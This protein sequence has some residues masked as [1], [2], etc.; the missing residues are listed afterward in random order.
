M[1]KKDPKLTVLQFNECINNQDA[2]GLANLMTEGIL[3][4]MGGQTTQVGKD[5]NTNA[6]AAFFNMCPD[7]KNHFTRI[8]SKDDRVVII[9]FSTCSN[10][11]V[12]G[13]ALWTAKVQND[14]IAEWRILEDT[15]ENRKSL[16]CN[17]SAASCNEK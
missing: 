1:N 6:W 15:K 13:P 10:K 5:A 8:E 2:D 9:G 3:M 14:L 12:E 11:S 7:Y 4:I 16:M 17:P